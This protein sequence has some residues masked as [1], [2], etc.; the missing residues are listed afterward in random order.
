MVEIVGHL[1]HQPDSQCGLRVEALTGEEEP[2]G[3]A[4]ADLG[5]HE[6]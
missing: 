4:L 6:R 1:V 5:E 3:G 2:K